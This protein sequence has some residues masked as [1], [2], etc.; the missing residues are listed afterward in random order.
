MLK[1]RLR[2]DIS[3]SIMPFQEIPTWNVYDRWLLHLIPKFPSMVPMSSHVG[4][5]VSWISYICS[6]D[7]EL[8]IGPI[9]QYV[10]LLSIAHHV[11]PSYDNSAS[12]SSSCVLHNKNLCIALCTSIV[13][14]KQDRMNGL[15]H[16]FPLDD[17][18]TSYQ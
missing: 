11:S 9:S 3:S 7:D 13:H 16:V 14:S 1:P 6:V 15:G 2:L 8:A 17:R 18:Q 12:S 4:V 5:G 10:C